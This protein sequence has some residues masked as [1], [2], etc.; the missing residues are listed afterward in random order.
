MKK[1]YLLLFTFLAIACTD[2]NLETSIDTDISLANLSRAELDAYILNSLE[3]TG[4]FDWR[5]EDVEL[6]WS[7][8]S[9][10]DYVLEVGYGSE[11]DFSN[12]QNEKL[13]EVK[14]EAVIQL[15]EEEEEFKRSEKTLHQYDVINVIDIEVRKLETLKKLRNHPDV[16][17]IEPIAYGFE[18][19]ETQEESNPVASTSGCVAA[20]QSINNNYVTTISPG[21]QVTWNYAEHNIQQAWGSATGA[22]VTI[23]LI[24]SGISQ[25]QYYLNSA[26]IN[27]GY[28]NNRSVEK[29]GTFIDSNW[30]WS[31]NYDGPHDKCGH[32]TSMA[33][34][35]GAPR[36]ND[37]LPVG[38]AY[39]SNI[40]S[41]R[42]TE[43]VVLNDY[44]ERK[45]VTDALIALANR[46]DVKIISM[47]IGYPWSIG[48]IRDAVK[49]AHSRGKL[50]VAAGGTSLDFTSWYG[51]IFPASMS[52][53]V[54]VTGV[55]DANNYEKCD[56]CHDGSAID[57]T[58][59]I[60][61]LDN[62]DYGPVIHGF[63]TNQRRY[64]GGSSAATASTAG[65]AAL[66]WEEHPNWSRAQVIQKLK[67]SS[68]F[69][70]NRDSELG[71]GNINA[72][73]A[74]N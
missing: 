10:S 52:E 35:F 3:E 68:D 37:N 25:S 17:Y 48:N 50:I 71:Y 36:N 8:L 30:W 60:Q 51:V 41:Y 4:S 45:G 56:I 34:I 61:T 42:A 44:H 14:R 40:V 63:S 6:I 32:G 9:Y 12:N 23:G 15:I 39:N 19:D 33:S 70:P 59:Q 69:Y 11:D 74:V 72:L 26:G 67:E 2:E 54:A 13:N 58:I 62:I 57:F 53:T 7:A 46:S 64:T 31:S 65:I 66:V 49:Y 24:D 27:D 38:V 29:Y 22:G 21:S 73:E 16:R 1:I 5:S 20:P 28:S 18:K 47:S 55:D 43:D